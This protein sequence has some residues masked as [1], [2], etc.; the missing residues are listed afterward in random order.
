MGLE[1]AEACTERRGGQQHVQHVQHSGDQE[2]TNGRDVHRST[3]VKER[4]KVE[5][6]ILRVPVPVKIF[7]DIHGQYG[8]L[9]QYFAQLGTPCDWM[10]NGPPDKHRLSSHFRCL[11][12]Q[13]DAFARGAAALTLGGVVDGGGGGGAAESDESAS[14]R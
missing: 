12:A 3:T 5:S 6:P 14:H 11:P 13:T 2:L 7:G 9:M 4:L 1:E 10:P 8:D